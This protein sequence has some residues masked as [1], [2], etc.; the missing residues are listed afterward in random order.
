MFRRKRTSGDFGA[1][2][3]AHIELETQ[4]LREEGLDEEE[5]RAAAR[6]SFGNL[7]RVE[8]RFYESGRWLWWD[9]FW[10]DARYGLRMLRRSPGFTAA[11]ILTMAVGI[12][13]TTAI[14]SVVDATLLRPL[15]YPHPGELVAVEDDLVGAGAS[16]VGLSEPEWQDLQRSGIFEYVSP[17]WFDENNLTGSCQPARVKIVSVAPNYFALLGVKPQLG[18]VFDPADHRPGFTLE[19]I[20]SDGLWKRGFGGDP[21]ILGKSIRLDT[22]LY[23]IVGVMPPGFH[24]PGRTAEERNVDVWP[25]TSFYGAPML[26]HPPR[27]R[28]NLPGAI[29]RLK[30]GLTM[31]QAQGRLDALVA[32]LRKQFPADYPV[33]SGWTVRLI[34]L[35]ESVVG[36]AQPPLVLLFGAVGLVLLIG[37]V[38]VANLLLAR[39]SARAREMAVRQSLGAARTRLTRQLLTESV[40]LSSLGGLT[41]LA[42]LFCTKGFLV[43]LVPESLP[44]LTDISINGSVLLYALGASLAAGVIFGLAPALQARRLDLIRAL[45]LEGRGSAGS[46]E[47]T[48]TRRLLVV[49]EFALSLV[50][51]IAASLLLRSFW[52]LLQAPLG[53][54]PR[55]VVT[56]RTRL[57]YPNDPTTDLY[58]TVSQKASFFREIIRRNR[59]LPGVEEVALGNSSSIPLDHAQRDLN[60]LGVIFE[61]PGIRGS[62]PSFVEASLVTPE[63]FHLIGMTVLRGRSFTGF[64]DDKTPSVAMVNEAMAR[65]YW[66][67]EDPIGKRLKLSATA[68]AWTTVIGVVADARTE[69]LAEAPAPQIFA[70]LYQVGEKHLAIFLRGHLDTAAIPGGVLKQVQSLDPRLPVFG[71]RT[72]D[73][74]VS[75]SLA[76]RRF[77]MEMVALFALTALLLAGLGIY[78]VISYLVSERTHEI[79]IRLALGAGRERI[80]RMVLRQGLSLALAGSG[81]GLVCALIVSRLM[82]GLLY[83]VR[84]SDPLTFTAVSVLLIAA[85]L[86]ACY[87]PARR[88]IRVEP[89][90]ALRHE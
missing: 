73:E 10:Q 47:Q 23:R 8:E 69:S 82:A 11:A 24:A 78:G 65:A 44:R 40:I 77:A 43:R 59:A 84:P 45:K 9:H 17:A 12:G 30:R 68:A 15:P 54:D 71:A 51:M 32:S 81:V 7:V 62:E 22:D 58:R 37:C 2:I 80:L 55:R 79:G 28:R 21:R 66:P 75:E 67:G 52:N 31:A 48:R 61:K 39:S 26:D 16:D 6:R 74:T 57:P 34:P 14:F 5:A 63:Y 1:E 86:L 70:S 50:L 49:A 3:E 38:N 88:A 72:L 41:G 36:N 4:R 76:E 87:I 64:D 83:G 20:I 35:K 33:Q 89:L 29:A 13:A 60:Q 27:N 46:G 53:F 19:V 42:I 25:A 56:V 85:A 18:R 90:V